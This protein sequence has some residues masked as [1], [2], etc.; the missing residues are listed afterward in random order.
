[1][2][3][4]EPFHVNQNYCLEIVRTSIQNEDLPAMSARVITRRGERRSCSCFIYVGHS[5]PIYY[6]FPGPPGNRRIVCSSEALLFVRRNSRDHNSP[7]LTGSS[8]YRLLGGWKRRVSCGVSICR[9]LCQTR[10][11]SWDSS[12]TRGTTNVSKI[13]SADGLRSRQR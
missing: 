13:R 7:S 11:R 4:L 2:P 9:S 12:P 5:S 8:T 1:M 3:P 10:A 6:G